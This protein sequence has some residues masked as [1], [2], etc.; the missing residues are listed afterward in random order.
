MPNLLLVMI[1]GALGAGARYQVGRFAL[2]QWGGAFPW[3]T[4]IVNLLGGLLIGALAGLFARNGAPVGQDEPMRLLLG[5]GVLGGFTTFSAFSLETFAMIERGAFAAASAYVL[6]SVAGA[7][8][9]VAA[10][11][12]LARAAA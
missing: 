9:L 5:V 2:H 4:L 6:A 11:L 1:G 12:W 8:V 10:G 3:G 7:L